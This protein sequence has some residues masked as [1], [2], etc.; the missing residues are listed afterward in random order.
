M[1]EKEGKKLEIRP[2]KFNGFITLW[3]DDLLS[4]CY[5]NLLPVLR[6]YSLSPSMAPQISRIG[7]SGM[8]TWDQIREVV[9]KDGGDVSWHATG[10][11]S[12]DYT[13]AELEYVLVNG[14]ETLVRRS[15]P[16]G[17]MTI[18]FEP[19]ALVYPKGVIPS[20]KRMGMLKQYFPLAFSIVDGGDV[21]AGVNYGVP[22]VGNYALQRIKVNDDNVDSVVNKLS[23]ILDFVSKGAW[24]NFISHG[25]RITQAN[26]R[27]FIEALMEESYPIRPAG[28]VLNQI[29]PGILSEKPYADKQVEKIDGM[30]VSSGEEHFTSQHGLAGGGCTRRETNTGERIRCLHD[31]RQS[32][33]VGDG[34]DL[35]Q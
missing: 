8:M 20:Q 10:S 2:R 19:P 15:N 4:E 14:Y 34:T 31:S 29:A 33:A 16:N 6:D 11:L 21:D 25:D 7:D 5:T 17:D 32:D 23:S 24:V 9:F 1:V 27:K 18:G 26:Y 13:P 28:Y 30:D 35:L 12:T 3:W 22:I